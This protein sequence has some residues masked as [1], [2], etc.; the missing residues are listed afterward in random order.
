MATTS[1]TRL[2]AKAI[3]PSLT[4]DDLA[5]SIRF[6]EALGFGIEERWE[7]GGVLLGAMLKAGEARIGISQDDWKRGRDRHKGVGMRVYIETAQN[8]DDLAAQ[9]K[10]A[11]IALDQEPHETPWGTRAFE[12]TEPSGFKLTISSGT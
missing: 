7:E 11:G 8:V 10:S 4:V 5:R 3:T 2:Q 1:D 6:F 12:I 9:V